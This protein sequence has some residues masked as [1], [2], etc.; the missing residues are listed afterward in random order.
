M[1]NI[2]IDHIT[3]V[4]GHGKLNVNLKE[5]K[6]ESVE[7][8]IFEGARYFEA[9]VLGR[10]FR[11]VPE[12]TS[13]ICGICSQSHLL[14]AI[15][16]L[17]KALDVKVT[18]Q[19]QQLRELMML[20]H[21]M[22]S[23]V[24]HLY[25]LALPDYLGYDSA[26]QMASKH[27][28]HVLRGL[29]LKKFSNW[30]TTM[31]G[32][33]EIHSI[34]PV[35]GG[36]TRLPSQ[37]DIKEMHKAF[38]EIKPDIEKT[39]NLFKGLK[40]PKFERDTQYVAIRN[41]NTINYLKGD[42]ICSSKK[43]CVPGRYHSCIKE[44]VVD[45]SNTKCVTFDGKEFLVGALAR[46]NV[47]KTL[48]SKNTKSI[49]SKLKVKFPSK[50]PYHNNLAQAVELMD[51]YDKSVSI[52][53][54]LKVKEEEPAKVKPKA[55]KG[56][57]IIEAPRGLLFHEYH[58]DAKG[59]IKKANII[60]PTT[61]NIKNIEEDIKVLLPELMK[62]TKNEKK[63]AHEMEVLIRAYDPCISCSTHFLE[64]NID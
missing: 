39:I 57:S 22:Q 42:L 4:E 47:N 13:R 61:Q 63:L 25:F 31:I 34:R 24:L 19:T 11:D 27:K 6:V 53:S 2:S 44:E 3:K 56:V 35:V 48:L 5:G 8:N 16:A 14:C 10:N 18:K 59:N 32:G 23:H 45:Y 9:L 55:G 54:Q 28:N 40:Y 1:K 26:L 17:E 20:A 46:V 30:I 52:L 33:R 7:V 62:K 43:K 37:D 29:K 41:N 36:F 49:L 50:N 51:F 38:K 60:A 64:L 12:V 15:Q 21:I 58:L